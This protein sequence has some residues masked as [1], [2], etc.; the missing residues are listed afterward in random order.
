MNNRI[1]LSTALAL[2][3][4][5]CSSQAL[6]AEVKVAVAANF[7]APVGN[8]IFGIAIFLLVDQAFPKLRANRNLPAGL[9]L[10]C[11]DVHFVSLKVN[12]FPLQGKYF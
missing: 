11:V 8:N 5:L 4:V 9:G 3:A 7:L 12:I 2:L 10:C 6:A 1:C